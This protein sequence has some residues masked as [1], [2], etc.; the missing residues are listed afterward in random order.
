MSGYKKPARYTTQCPYC[1]AHPTMNQ[2]ARG[3]RCDGCGHQRFLQPYEKVADDPDDL[4]AHVA[5]WARPSGVWLQLPTGRMRAFA[6][7]R[8][9]RFVTQ[10][11]CDQAAPTNGGSAAY[12]QDSAEELA[13]GRSPR[14]SLLLA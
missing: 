12:T 10:L 1:S 11:R 14:R 2:T 7:V 5:A 6:S 3:S 8:V 9:G 4:L 13:P